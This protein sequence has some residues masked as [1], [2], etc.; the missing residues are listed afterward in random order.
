MNTIKTKIAIRLLAGLALLY[1]GCSDNSVINPTENTSYGKDINE[2]NVNDNFDYATTKD[3]EINITTKMNSKTTLVNFPVLVYDALPENGGNILT[4]GASDANGQLQLFVSIPKALDKVYAVSGAIGLP[5]AIE[6]STAGTSISLDY[7]SVSTSPVFNTGNVALGKETDNKYKV[8]GSWD[9]N[10]TPKYSAEE[11]EG[12]DSKTLENINVS[13]PEYQNVP[14]KHPEY[15][16]GTPANININ[17]DAEVYVTFLSE[18]ASYRN[19][20]GF[21][22]FPT[23]KNP[24]KI[25]EIESNLT[26]IF[27]N[28]SLPGSGGNLRAGTKVTIGKF[29]SGISIG[30]FVI[31]NGFNGINQPGSGNGTFYSDPILNPES[32]SLLRRHNVLLIDPLTK[33]TILG[34]EDMARDKGADNDFNDVLFSIASNPVEAIDQSKMPLMKETIDTDGD[35]IAD[36]NDAYPSDKAKAFNTYIP[37]KGVNGSLAFEDLWP[38]KGDYDFN[39]MVVDYNYNLITNAQNNVVELVANFSL[40]AIGASFRNGFGI[41]LNNS[42]NSVTVTGSKLSEGIV[43]LAG[44]G[45]EEGQDKATII[46]FE[47]A[48]NL[49]NSSGGAYVN[50]ENG[51]SYVTPKSIP[52]VIKFNSPVS[53]A[54]LGS[55]PFNPFIFI[56][57][58]RSKEVHLVN[59]A[60]TKKADLSILGTVDDNSSSAQSRYYKTKK[61]LPWALNIPVAFDYPVEKAAITSAYPN[62]SSWTESNGASATNWYTNASGNRKVTNIYIKK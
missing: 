51:Y 29:A 30:W 19:V 4:S 62:F 20:L 1:V 48:Y 59:N 33:K 55:A 58:E 39:D 46:V 42:S 16:Q 13:L 12:F 38:A 25:N 41:Q 7:S 3:I 32:D 6:L 8:L 44:N 2:L 31:S 40:R 49:M 36:V 60:P 10:G 57:K 18:G 21:Y 56:N 53:V 23:G 14:L 50:T 61:N 34:F 26:I 45:V 27:P 24:V 15:I 22:T 35:G 37:A 11:V 43:K 17:K 52:V 5:S 9:A 28:C 47:N 54:S